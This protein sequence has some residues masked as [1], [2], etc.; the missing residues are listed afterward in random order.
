[1]PDVE[2]RVAVVGINRQE[3]AVGILRFLGVG[4]G[5]LE[6]ADGS[7][8]GVHA[9]IDF[10][11]QVEG[12][13]HAVA[14]GPLLGV[15]VDVA[16]FGE[17]FHDVFFI[18]IVLHEQRPGVVII[19]PL[20]VGGHELQ[21]LRH[22]RHQRLALVVVVIIAEQAL[23]TISLALHGA[24]SVGFVYQLADVDGLSAVVIINGNDH[25]PAEGFEALR[26]FQ[27]GQPVTDGIGRRGTS[28][29]KSHRKHDQPQQEAQS[30][31]VDDTAAC[32]HR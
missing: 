15:D 27:M 16:G 3:K 14:V 6:V 5:T 18:E 28:G 25:Q 21:M 13:G 22:L 2:E 17:C 23:A 4:E 9:R 30:E 32:L 7:S 29:G 31:M 20:L 10:A 8:V 11:Q 1:M 24:L 12:H 26:A 19:S